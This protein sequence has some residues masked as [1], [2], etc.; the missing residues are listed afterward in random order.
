M[1]KDLV[2]Q[3]SLIAKLMAEYSE[4]ALLFDDTKS[5]VQNLENLKTIPYIIS[6]EL[7]NAEGKFFASYNNKQAVNSKLI[8][9]KSSSKFVYDELQIYEPIYS[10]ENEQIGSIFLRVSLVELNKNV[11]EFIFWMLI[12]I[13]LV[14]IIITLMASSFQKIISRPIIAL[15]NLT[16]EISETRDYSMR[17]QKKS[18]DEIGIL[19]DGFN[20]MLEVIVRNEIAM[21]SAQDKLKESEEQFS[22][23]ME[24]LPAA[25]FIKE[26]DSKYRY[27]N[28]FLNDMFDANKWIGN[29]LSNDLPS[30]K[31]QFSN[32][33]DK[34]ALEVVQHFDEFVYDKTNE[35]RYFETWKF[36]LYR[37]EKDTLIGGIAID[38]TERKLIENQINYYIKELERNNQ[39]LEEF[40]YVASHDLRE[41]L[42]TITSYCD[43][44]S[45]DIGENVND[46]VKE[47]I[48]FITDA[49]TRMNTLIQDLLQLSRAGRIEYELEKVDLNKL[50]ET[51]LKDLELKLKESNTSIDLKPLP[52]LMADYT[53]LGRVFQNLLTNAIKFKSDKDPKIKIYSFEKNN[54]Y[55]I[56][57]EDNGIGIE[58]QYFK[59]IFAAFKRLH[60]RD[61][62]DGTG[63][64]L[65]ICKKI[66]E[67]HNGN[68]RIE[69]IPGEGSKFIITLKKSL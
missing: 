14:A 41:P 7:Y 15:T 39:E 57:F 13:A 10:S 20:N 38:T 63:I 27:V 59:Q 8:I 61:E 47:D 18:N 19:Y 5:A 56:Y 52:T 54:F 2:N 62:Y 17:I 32:L 29:I 35:L 43:L 31:K 65:A 11:N 16:E 55:D 21:L 33:N 3:S 60:S 42:R 6:A 24:M 68:L 12:I 26:K 67:R 25:A 48:K 30:E 23:F 34:E 45:E 46:M 36:P 40:N 28:K 64:G 37:R 50:I 1:K 49:T 4:F 58:K 51:V 9:P 66:I 53:Q 22:T 69:S 44:L